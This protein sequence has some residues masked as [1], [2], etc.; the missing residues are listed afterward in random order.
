MKKYLAEIAGAISILLFVGLCT[1]WISSKSPS[2]SVS[3]MMH[4]EIEVPQ[5]DNIG[6]LLNQQVIPTG[7]AL[8]D[9]AIVSRP[10]RG[11]AGAKHYGTMKNGLVAHF[12]QFG[13]HLD[14]IAVFAK[15]ESVKVVRRGLNGPSLKAF[16]MRYNKIVAKYKK[17]QYSAM[18]NNCEH[19]VTELVFGVK[20]SAQSKFAMDA[21]KF[22][23]PMIIEEVQNSKFAF[24]APGIQLALN[25]ITGDTIPQ[26]DSTKTK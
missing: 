17:S 21:I 16:E 24:A 22:Y 3:Q 18:Q 13:F 23:K 26:S 9:G 5:F 15:D 10:I 4:R 6:T 20:A 12:N 7:S 1:W 8:G 2:T 11:L 14:S 25:N 19:F